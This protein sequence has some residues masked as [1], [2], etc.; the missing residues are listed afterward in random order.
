MQRIETLARRRMEIERTLGLL[1]Q[2]SCS[3]A[4]SPGANRQP[5]A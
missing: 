2:N 5:T 4:G 1:W 3:P